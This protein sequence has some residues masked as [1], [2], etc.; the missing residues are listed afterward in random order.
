MIAPPV[1]ADDDGEE[2]YKLTI[3][4]EFQWQYQY[5]SYHFDL[6]DGL[7]KFALCFVVFYLFVL[8][9]RACV[10]RLFYRKLDE[11]I[12]EVDH[13]VHAQAN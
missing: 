8:C 7:T 1:I 4:F 13:E 3:E 6:F 11:L 9:I 10:R 12:A 2:D 5:S